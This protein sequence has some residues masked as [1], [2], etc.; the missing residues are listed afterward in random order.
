MI[1]FIDVEKV[2]CKFNICP[3]LKTSKK[4]KNKRGILRLHNT[5]FLFAWYTMCL[6]PNQSHA[7]WEILEAFRIRMLTITNLIYHHC[8]PLVNAVRKEKGIKKC[9]I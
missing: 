1:I 9:L 7:K 3:W 6:T 5:L 4:K 2:L 8:G